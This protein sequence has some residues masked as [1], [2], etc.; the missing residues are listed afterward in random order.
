MEFGLIYYG[1]NPRGFNVS[2]LY[3]ADIIFDD[4]MQDFIRN[5]LLV[6]STMILPNGLYL[7]LDKGKEDFE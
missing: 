7:H 6:Y 5:L 3:K 4:G 1:D 2:S